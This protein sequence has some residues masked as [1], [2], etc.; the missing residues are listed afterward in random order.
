VQNVVGAK[1]LD[2]GPLLHLHEALMIETYLS[3]ALLPLLKTPFPSE[4]LQVK[5]EE[6]K[7]AQLKGDADY[8]DQYIVS[9]FRLVRNDWIGS[10]I[11]H[12]C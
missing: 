9:L 5:E 3:A 10:G 2:Y 1:R 11:F 7:C 8:N 6:H 4:E 12:F